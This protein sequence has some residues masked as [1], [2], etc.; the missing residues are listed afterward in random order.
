MACRTGV[1][2]LSLLAAPPL[3]AQGDGPLGEAD[4]PVIRPEL[5]RRDIEEPRIDADNIEIGAFAG[6]LSVEDFGVNAFFGARA[7]YHVTEDLFFELS[8]GTSR[9][10]ETSFERLSGGAT[11][12]A[13][14]ERRFTLYTLAA[15]YN[16]L[17]GESFIGPWFA[18]NSSLFVVA[19][20]GATEFAG[21]TRFTASFGAGYQVLPLDWLALRVDFRDHLMNVDVTGEDKT[22]HNLEV[23]G[24]VTVFF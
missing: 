17:P 1:L 21:E 19:G 14:D 22:T 6:L 2:L 15:G 3:A 11:L 24:G 9:T 7:A 12:L 13:D 20:A 18:L 10:D 5:E 4:A 8:A 23:T 16:L